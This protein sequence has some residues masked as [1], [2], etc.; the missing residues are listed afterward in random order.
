MT[1]LP[2]RPS[3]GQPGGCPARRRPAPLYGPHLTGDD[4]PALYEL[5]RTRHGPVA[6]VALAP[7]VHAWLV[8][9]YRELLRVARDER[10]FS[11]DPR[12]WTLPREGRV[13][14]DSPVLAFVGWRPA[15]MFTDGRQ[16][17]RMRAAVADALARTDA[18]ELGRL[19]RTAADRLI[20]AFAGRREADLVPHYA[21]RLPARVLT[22]LLGADERTGR[23][24]AEAAAGT[25]AANA[26]SANAGRRMERLLFALIEEKRRRPGP[27]IVSRLLAHPAALSDEE[28]L[29]NLAV[30]VVAGNQ[31]TKNW[32]AATL[33][34]MLTDPALRSSLDGGHLTVD[35]VL[36]LV[37]WRFPPTQ[38]LPARY[39]T[40]DLRFGGQ[41]VRAG[42]M[43]VLGLAAANADPRVL[44]RCGRPVAGNRS[45]LAFGAGPHTCPAQEQARLI[46]RTAVD[47]LRHRLP[48]LRLAVPEEELVWTASPWTRSLASLPVRFAGPR[49]AAVPAAPPTIPAP[50]AS[51][52]P[53]PPPPGS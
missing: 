49:P 7:G 50:A 41:D 20:D 35:D 29:H 15:L 51:E 37:L 31:T 40:R 11:H 21:H 3:A 32:I 47:V 18:H 2:R 10:D 44:P 23:K 12:R 34:A 36:E 19:V 4:L 5:L 8:L 1:A 45:H 39:A 27:D 43:L 6:P 33:R 48:G 17:R 30:T 13:P 53:V 42:D 9:G 28:V 24:L 16:H 25:A 26:D 46:A 14:A 38:H 52:A 22:R